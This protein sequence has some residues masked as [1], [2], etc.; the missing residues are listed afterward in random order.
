MTRAQNNNMVRSMNILENLTS[1]EKDK[2][3][4]LWDNYFY[5]NS[6]EALTALKIFLGAKK[7]CYKY[8]KGWIM[9]IN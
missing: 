9:G 4:E 7:I 8:F 5:N 3:F 2:I 1:N 6:I